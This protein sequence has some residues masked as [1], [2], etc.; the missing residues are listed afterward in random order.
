M[1]EFPCQTGSGFLHVKVHHATAAAKTGQFFGRTQVVIEHHQLGGTLFNAAQ[2]MLGKG[3]IKHIDRPCVQGRQI[4]DRVHI[5]MVKRHK[6]GLTVK[7]QPGRQGRGKTI[8]TLAPV[9]NHQG[10]R[11]ILIRNRR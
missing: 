7:I 11:I 10:L 8:R 6:L 4:S 9:V 2:D 1:K 5:T 3:K